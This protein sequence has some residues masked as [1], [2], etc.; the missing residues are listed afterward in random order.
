M[1]R[2]R[3]LS[4]KI[5]EAAATF[6]KAASIITL[7]LLVFNWVAS[8]YNIKRQLEKVS[9]EVWLGTATAIAIPVFQWYKS[10][11]QEEIKLAQDQAKI[12]AERIETI[13]KEVRE[14]ITRLESR[15]NATLI[16][17]DE[18]RKDVRELAEVLQATDQRN[19]E[20]DEKIDQYR[21]QVLQERLEII[22]EVY[23]ELCSLHSSLSYMKGRSSGT[24]NLPQIE[25]IAQ[26]VQDKKSDFE[27]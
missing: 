8:R 5:K 12:G 17:L 9:G 6:V 27:R 19:L 14:A 13:R 15:Y 16:A 22:K 1:E 24:T 21:Y 4:P 7:G 18:L 20:L 25:A 26:S 11:E 2:L 23:K 10:R 3:L